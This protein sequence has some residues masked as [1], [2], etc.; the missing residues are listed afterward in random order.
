MV[1][2]LERW[3]WDSGELEQVQVVGGDIEG[4]DEASSMQLLWLSF[5]LTLMV[6]SIKFPSLHAPLHTRH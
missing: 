6:C 4:I 5:L 2:E 3:H 1:K